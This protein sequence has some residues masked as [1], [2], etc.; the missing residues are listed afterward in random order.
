MVV[1][2]HAPSPRCIRPW[3][4]GNPFNLAFAANLD[5]LIEQYQPPL[6]I[7]GHMHDPVDEWVGR[8]R[9]LANPAGYPQENNTDFNP[10]LCV[11]LQNAL[12]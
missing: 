8:T 1:T 9:I 6:W 10:A 7:H 2:H 5:D 12:R 3:F 11:D 4:E